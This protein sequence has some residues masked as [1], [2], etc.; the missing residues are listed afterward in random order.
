MRA[1]MTSGTHALNL[2]FDFRALNV[3]L[4]VAEAGGMTAAARRLGLTQ[5]AVSQIMTRLETEL[6]ATLI[7][8]GQRPYQPTPAGEAFIAGAR[9]LLAD[10]ERLQAATRNAAGATL[11]VARIGLIDSFAATVGPH[12]IRGLRN[13][14]RHFSVWSGI[15]PNL[16]DDLVHRK[17]DFI[18]TTDPMN[19]MGGIERHRLLR[20]PFLLVLPK[21]MARAIKEVRLE[22]LARNHPFVRYSVRSRIGAQIEEY[23]HRLG[24]EVPQSLEFDGSEPVFAMVSGGLAWAITTPLC[25]IHGRTA[26][27][28]L[29]PIP[30]PGPSLSRT[31]YLLCRE[32]EF[33]ALPRRIA[34]DARDILRQTIKREGQATAPWAVKETVVG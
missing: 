30:L 18:V 26:E 3:F 4:A 28:A 29:A 17:L 12:L 14:A 10:A 31:L 5:P 19:T 16:T 23:L 33:G 25:L 7:D 1:R 11:P 34:R 15:S 2:A 24:L 20:E 32:G 9:R 27:M 21:R 22:D 13:Q 8:R 6:G